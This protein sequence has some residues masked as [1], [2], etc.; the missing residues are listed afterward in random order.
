V[1]ARQIRAGEKIIEQKAN[2]DVI[3]PPKDDHIKVD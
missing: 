1:K 3:E 2:V